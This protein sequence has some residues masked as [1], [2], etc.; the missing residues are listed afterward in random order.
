MVICVNVCLE[1]IVTC[2]FSIKYCCISNFT[3]D[4]VH[5][6]QY[7]LCI[8]LMDYYYYYS[9]GCLILWLFAMNYNVLGKTHVYLYIK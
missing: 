3:I 2:L 6:V 5:R 9:F 1:L 4:V 8:S 7:Y